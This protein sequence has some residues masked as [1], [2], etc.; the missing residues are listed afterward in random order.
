MPH[1]EENKPWKKLESLLVLGEGKALH[2]FLDTM[3]SAEI[4]RAISRLGDE[5][6]AN[7]LTLL[8]PEDAADLIEELSET[9]GADLIEDLDSEHAAAIVDE[10]ESDHRVDVL[11]EMD[12][13]DA[14][15]I[16]QEMNPEEAE[17]VRKL[18][19]H[20]PDTAGG[21]MITEFVVYSQ[22]LTVGDV[23]DDLRTNA[24]AYSDYG[25]QYA[26]VSSMKNTLIGVLRLRDLVLSSNDVPI[27]QVMIVNPVSVL[28]DTSLEELEQTFDRFNF[29]G[30]PVIAP[31]GNI[32]GVVQRADTEEALSNRAEKTFMRFSG[33][34]GGDEI[35]TEPVFVRST[36][37]L[38]WLA[39]N[40]VLSL[41]A[42]S[43]IIY[44]QDTVEKNIALAAL[45]P[46]LAN[47]SG[48]S[49]NQA[50]A[51]SIR[52]MTLG[53]ITHEDVARVVRMELVVG[54]FNGLILG[55]LLGGF[56][57]IWK[58]DMMLG[59]VVGLA[60]SLNTVLSVALGGAIP[61]L[62]RKVNIDPA[63]AAAPIL[64]TVVDMCGFFLILSLASTFLL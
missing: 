46:V 5:E 2:D 11:G 37:R 22:A 15:A 17:E 42:A 18:L 44:F 48:C 51:V 21:V 63:V 59:L 30:L 29:S 4:A 14:E 55:I 53:L 31:E 39:A 27:Q 26:Y 62:L 38:W 9:Q 25:V 12:K 33:I 16:I 20:D 43:V 13:D 34:I 47:L 3:N 52:E 24:E 61:L 23:L 8:E 58:G 28:T 41:M 60:L 35:R 45:I 7:L 50:I 64:T 57:L 1:R 54:I 36:Q 40:L 10:M 56:I 32:V 6:Q 19:E 49:G